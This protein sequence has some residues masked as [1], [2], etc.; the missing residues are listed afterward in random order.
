MEPILDWQ[1]KYQASATPWEREHLNPAFNQ[2]RAHFE[3][4]SGHVI[5][6]GCGRSPELLAMAAMGWQV[7][8]IDLAAAA[9]DFQSQA[10]RDHR[11]EGVVI[12]G[13]LFEW[14]PDEPADLIYEQTCLCALH[15]EQWL[16]YEAQLYR[17]LKPGGELAALF[18]QT[19]RDGGPPFDCP[20]EDM[21]SLFAPQRWHWDTQSIV[22]EHP[23]GVREHGFL[24][25]RR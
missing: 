12:Q 14:Q 24:L 5:L 16:A 9:V 15:P 19:G 20:L 13:N 25:T 18:M 21:R 17:W 4:R 8:G 22:S 7:T 1:A 11:F 3:Q 2:W 10:L 6:P 23:L